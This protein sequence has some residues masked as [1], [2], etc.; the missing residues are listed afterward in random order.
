MAEMMVVRRAG[1]GY[2]A[3]PVLDQPM[4]AQQRQIDGLVTAART[5]PVTF[6]QAEAVHTELRL[7]ID[8]LAAAVAELR[9]RPL[10]E[11]PAGPDV[12]LAPL[13]EAVAALQAAEA[14]EGPPPDLAPTAARLGQLE[15]AV[16]ELRAVVAQL[17]G[18]L[19]GVLPPG[20]GRKP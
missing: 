15:A 13:Q 2:M 18:G 4:A 10:P 19:G 12:D 16:A 6:G 11:L 7:A 3:V 20:L 14:A 5:L 8:Q 9:D 1:G 17:P